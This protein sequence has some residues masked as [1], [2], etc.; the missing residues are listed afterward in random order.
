MSPKTT[1]TSKSRSAAKT[2]TANK[3]NAWQQLEASLAN[4]LLVVGVVFGT[5][6]EPDRLMA[7]MSKA[8]ASING[9]YGVS[10]AAHQLPDPS[11]L[12]PELLRKWRPTEDV[13]GV[14]LRRDRA[15][16]QRFSVPQEQ[17]DAVLAFD[18]REACMHA[19]AIQ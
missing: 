8:V 16:H 13:I 6:R 2:G 10:V 14:I 3:D 5:G 4:P 1:Q 17:D 9:Q 7:A 11:V 19:L 15:V 18:V 12:D